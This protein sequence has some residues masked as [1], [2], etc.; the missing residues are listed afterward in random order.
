MRISKWYNFQL[1]DQQQGFRQGRGTTDGIFVVKRIQQICRASNKKVYAL[2]VDLSAAFDHVN[3]DW[4]FKT[5]IQR[6]PNKC[7][8]KLIKILQEIYKHTTTSLEGDPLGI[9]GLSAKPDET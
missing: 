9:F 5:I 7:N 8:H 4:M 6:I 2:F 3:R 1:A